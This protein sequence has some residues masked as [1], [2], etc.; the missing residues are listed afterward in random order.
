[1]F[2]ETLGDAET[3]TITAQ[4]RSQPAGQ[5]EMGAGRQ[6]EEDEILLCGNGVERHGWSARFR[7]SFPKGKPVAPAQKVFHRPAHFAVAEDEHPEWTIISFY[8]QGCQGRK[9]K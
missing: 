3:H 5:L 4:T 2:V 8:R 6:A 7:V 9:E 1:V